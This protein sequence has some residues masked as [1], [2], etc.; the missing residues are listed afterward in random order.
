MDVLSKRKPVEKAGF[1]Y[2]KNFSPAMQTAWRGFYYISPLLACT[3]IWA[4][5]GMWVRGPLHMFPI[6]F[7]FVS[8]SSSCGRYG[9]LDVILKAYILDST[10]VKPVNISTKRR[11]RRFLMLNSVS[12][13]KPAFNRRFF[14]LQKERDLAQKGGHL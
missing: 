5:C 7:F 13:V 4:G 2:N 1:L 11:R 9:T 14:P 12:V 10:N 8:L 6:I 3:G